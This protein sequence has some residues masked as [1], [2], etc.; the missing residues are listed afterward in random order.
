MHNEPI[1]SLIAALSEN[2]V[3]G[4]KG[5]IP[6]HIKKDLKRFWAKTEGHLIVMGRKTF[7]S[8]LSYY[9]KSKKSFP[10][11]TFIIITRK[12]DYKINQP[13]C[14]VVHSIKQALQL[15]E[16]REEHEIFIAGGAQIY[17]QTIGLA[18]KLYLTILKGKFKGDAFFPQY[19]G[20]KIVADSGWQKE[21]NYQ[22]KFLNLVRS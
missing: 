18:N 20:F 5:K 9:Q 19:S 17:E 11:R 21:G 12:K 4:D 8:V 7:S 15:A 6:W 3:I 2:R 10:K 13:D 22:F 14:F 16:S 1:I